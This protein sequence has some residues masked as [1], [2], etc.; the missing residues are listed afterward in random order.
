VADK[1]IQRAALKNSLAAC[2]S[3]LQK[4]V[5]RHNILSH[6]KLPIATTDM[7][8][9]VAAASLDPAAVHAIGGEVPPTAE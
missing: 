4:H 5:E 3:S 9:M 8:K 1:A 2:S 7:C 6:T